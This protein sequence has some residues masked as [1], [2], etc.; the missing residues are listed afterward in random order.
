MAENAVSQSDCRINKLATSQE[1]L[2]QPAWFFY[3]LL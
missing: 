1:Q 2:G 3:M